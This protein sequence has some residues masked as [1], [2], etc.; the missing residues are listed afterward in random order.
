[1]L[2]K[3]VGLAWVA[4]LIGAFGW[5]VTHSG[6][7]KKLP[8]YYPNCAAARRAGVAPIQRGEAGY[9]TGLDADGDGVACEPYFG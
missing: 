1:M 7:L 4:G 6:N 3:V 8:T 2:R 9:R 5:L